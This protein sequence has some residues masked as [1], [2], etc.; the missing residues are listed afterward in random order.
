[1][2]REFKRVL[3]AAGLPLPR[4]NKTGA[5]YL[6]ARYERP[7]ITIELQSFRYHRSRK[8]W[9][10]DFER[11]RAARRR[12][13]AFLPLTWHDVFEATREMLEELAALLGIPAKLQ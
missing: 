13:D 9:E 5:H 3:E 8:A 7:P 2:E 11:Q 10:A 4:F 12:G 1:M 6:D